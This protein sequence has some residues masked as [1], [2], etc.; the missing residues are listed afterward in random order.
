[1]PLARPPFQASWPTHWWRPEGNND[2][3]ARVVP[4]PIPSNHQGEPGPKLFVHKVMQDLSMTANHRR[5]HVLDQGL[6]VQ[7][8][9][10]MLQGSGFRV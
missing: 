7:D 4:F 2:N 8:S 3:F 9:G 1:M 6:R 10:F 5:R